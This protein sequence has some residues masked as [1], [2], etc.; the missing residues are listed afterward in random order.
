MFNFNCIQNAIINANAGFQAE[1]VVGRANAHR[2][3]PAKKTCDTSPV[4]LCPE[5]M[6]TTRLE[7]GGSYQRTNP[8]SWGS[9]HP[10]QSHPQDSWR[11][12]RRNV[13]GSKSGRT[14]RDLRSTIGG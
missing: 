14:M 3:L 12:N 6:Y 5:R 7:Q 10:L 8:S 9:M 1:L 2:V 4:S 13:N 11:L